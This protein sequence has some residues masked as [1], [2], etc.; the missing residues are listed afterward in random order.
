[1]LAV[2][3][4]LRSTLFR[5]FAQ[6]KRNNNMIMLSFARYL[7]LFSTMAMTAYPYI[8]VMNCNQGSETQDVDDAIKDVEEVAKGK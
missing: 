7:Y 6:I 3:T 2:R 8:I 4:W 5:Y 1:V